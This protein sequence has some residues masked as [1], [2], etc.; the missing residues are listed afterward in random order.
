VLLTDPVD[1]WGEVIGCFF[2]TENNERGA[3]DALHDFC[4]ERL[5]PR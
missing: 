3:A 2:R 5:S 4:R 1:K